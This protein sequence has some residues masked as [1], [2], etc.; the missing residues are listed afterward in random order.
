MGV[1]QLSQRGHAFKGSCFNT[2]GALSVFITRV[3]LLYMQ[4]P[5]LAHK[6]IAELE[7]R[8]KPQGRTVTVVTQNIDRLHH[9][10]GSQNV[11]ELHG[12][13]DT[14]FSV[15]NYTV[16]QILHF[17][18]RITRYNRYYILFLYRITR[19]NKYIFCRAWLKII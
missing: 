5:N 10:A 18:Y 19:Y 13:T 1:L 9:K 17:L 2:L 4:S 12:T 3:C 16:Q 14:I 11:I 7:A 8:L 6:A 15:S